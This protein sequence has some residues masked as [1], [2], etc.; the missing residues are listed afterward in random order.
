MILNLIN[1]ETRLFR[2]GARH[3]KAAADLRCAVL[4]QHLRRRFLSRARC[5]GDNKRAA[6]A[7][8]SPIGKPVTALA[9]KGK[10]ETAIVAAAMS[11]PLRG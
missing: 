1:Q 8:V 3:Y 6:V 9:W 2:R 5:T 10:V 4:R 7:R 11:V